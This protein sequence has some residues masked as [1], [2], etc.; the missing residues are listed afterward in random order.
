[1]LTTFA[2]AQA[3][4]SA[5]NLH[6]GT[7]IA[8]CI[9]DAVADLGSIDTIDEIEHLDRIEQNGVL[10]TIPGRRGCEIELRASSIIRDGVEYIAA[11]LRGG[12]GSGSAATRAALRAAGIEAR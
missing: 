2:A 9:E 4:A 1:M 7:W 12:N 6:V 10:L 3:E 11:D 8:R 5:R